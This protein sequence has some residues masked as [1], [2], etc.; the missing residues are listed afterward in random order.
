MTATEFTL[1]D[2][3]YNSY[4]KYTAGSPDDCVAFADSDEYPDCK[5]GEIQWDTADCPGQTSGARNVCSK[6]NVG[7]CEPFGTVHAYM[8]AYNA[9]HSSHP[10]NIKCSYRGTDFGATADVQAYVNYKGG[11]DAN[12][13]NIIMPYFASLPADNPP[14]WAGHVDKA[15]PKSALICSRMFSVG[16]DGDMCRQWRDAQLAAVDNGNRSAAVAYDNVCTG[17]C[18]KYPWLPECKCVVRNDPVYG[19]PNYRA[20]ASSMKTALPNDGCWYLPCADSSKVNVLVP[21]NE[22]VPGPTECDD[23]C[24]IINN[25]IDSSDID[26]KEMNQNMTCETNYNDDEIDDDDD[27]DDDDDNDYNPP[28]TWSTTQKVIVGASAGIAVLAMVGLGIFIVSS[29][30]AA[31]SKTKTVEPPKP[32]L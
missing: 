28:P 1:L 31:K 24:L 19:D 3:Q 20:L 4:E 17:W 9:D 10:A 7:E 16:P 5:Q 25:F 23:A 18:N 26:I 11:Q 32:D 21:S 29:S 6:V 13:T 8:A 14:S 22:A 12:F 2:K 27:D 30:F 15:D